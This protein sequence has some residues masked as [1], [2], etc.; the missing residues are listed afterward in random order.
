MKLNEIDLNKLATFFAVAE[1]GGVSAAARRLGRTRSAVSQSLSA[2]EAL[3]GARLFHRA[4]RRLVPTA[5]GLFLRRGL[6]AYQEGL[7]RTLAEVANEEREVRGLVRV[8]LYLGFSRLR[9]TRL[10]DGFLAD[11]PAV[12]VRV[13]FGSRGE[14]RERLL[15]GR[16]DFAFSLA[17]PGRAARRI[18]SSPLFEQEL[19]LAGRPALVRRVDGPES[20]AALPCVDYYRGDALLERWARHHFGRAE[21]RPSVRVWAATTD[22]VLE[23]VLAGT[24]LAVLPADLVE[25]H[26][27]R[28][29]A[30][31]ETARPPLRD[32]VFLDEPAAEWLPPRLSAFRER[33]LREF[34]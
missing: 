25:P 7:F 2:L 31:V 4:G 28:R 21:P 17:A 6:G 20:L 30:R 26:R 3:L 10:L 1:A 32:P 13:A 12:R 33:V 27:G 29:L 34:S 24:G 18:R 14:I 16:L 8:G 22:L 15:E 11:H 23:L 9:L 19:V 5:E